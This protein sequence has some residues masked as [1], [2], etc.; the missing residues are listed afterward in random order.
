MYQWLF[1]APQHPLIHSGQIQVSEYCHTQT[2]LPTSVPL[3]NSQLKSL[4]S[5]FYCFICLTYT[6]NIRKWLTINKPKGLFHLNCLLG[7]LVCLSLIVMP[8]IYKNG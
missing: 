5:Y 8:S 2:C 7:L 6:L 4:L 3:H 1:S